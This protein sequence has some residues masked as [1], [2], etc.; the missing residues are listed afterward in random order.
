MSPRR[1][2]A[3]AAA[4]A[5]PATTTA[6]DGPRE[7]VQLFLSRLTRKRLRMWAA[8]LDR[9]MS[10]LAE[11]AIAAHLDSRDHERAA[12]GLPPVTLE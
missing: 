1:R 8:L 10:D 5:E 4:R 6:E 3:A 11:E 12:R 7:K 2:P 9:D